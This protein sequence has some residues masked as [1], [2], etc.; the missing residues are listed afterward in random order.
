M[1]VIFGGI[2]CTAWFYAFPTFQEQVLWRTSAITIICL[3]YIGF[4]IT[5]F[6][7]RSRTRQRGSVMF[8]VFFSTSLALY[9]TARIILLTL[10][11]TTLRKLPSNAYK[12]VPWTSLLPHL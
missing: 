6:L 9:L 3:P 8:P 7:F 4:V 2:H 11:F 1:V 10:M 12:V 5:L